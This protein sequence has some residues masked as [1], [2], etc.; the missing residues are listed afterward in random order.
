ML[1][2]KGEHN[3]VRK[4]LLSMLRRTR[5][6]APS[7]I[8]QLPRGIDGSRKVRSGERHFCASF[9]HQFKRKNQTGPQEPSRDSDNDEDNESES[10]S[11][12]SED[13]YLYN[14]AVDA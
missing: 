7:N 5:Y 6:G 2:H 3:T 9:G 10:M 4:K 14:T 11:E 1:M 12:V 8:P 13:S